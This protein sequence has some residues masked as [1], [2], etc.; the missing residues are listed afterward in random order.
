MEPS[1]KKQDKTKY[2]DP[3]YHY[4]SQLLKIGEDYTTDKISV[5]E[6]VL[7]GQ[8]LANFPNFHRFAAKGFVKTAIEPGD[9]AHYSDDEESI[10]ATVPGYPK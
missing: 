7:A 1:P 5:S 8:L 2:L 6:L 4:T 3:T 9:Y 10:L